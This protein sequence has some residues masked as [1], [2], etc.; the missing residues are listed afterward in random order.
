M[1]R[2]PFD[3]EHLE[4][5]ALEQ[6]F[7]RAERIVA[8]VLVIDR[9]VLQRIDEIEQIVRLGDE[10]A[11]VREQLADAAVTPWTS[12]IWANTFAAV[13][14]FAGPRSACTWRASVGAEIIDHGF[15][16]ALTGDLGGTRRIDARARDAR[17]P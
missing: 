4:T 17:P 8:Q 1:G 3:V 10:D 5:V 16:A 11:V 13:T 9:V 15:D 14:T 12:P 2:N 7:E 6:A